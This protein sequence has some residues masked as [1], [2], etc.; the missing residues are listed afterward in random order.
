[1]AASRLIALCVIAAAV[2]THAGA[3]CDLPKLINQVQMHAVPY[4]AGS[5]VDLVPVTID[6]H[7][8]EFLLDTGGVYTQISPTLVAE[9]NLPVN[10][11]ADALVD[12]AGRQAAGLTMLRTFQLGSIT[13]QDVPLPLSPDAVIRTG[14]LSLNDLKPYDAEMDFG[15]NMLKLYSQ[16]HCSGVTAAAPSATVI[17]FSTVSG[18]I[19]LTVTLDGRA[20]PAIIDTGASYT[21][22]RADIAQLQFGAIPGGNDTPESGSINGMPNLTTYSHVF[23]SLALGG[24]TI[25]N[26]RVLILP[27][28]YQEGGK[29]VPLDAPE[30]ILGMNVLKDLDLYFAFDE[31][32]LYVKKAVAPP[33]S[34]P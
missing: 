23:T 26:P 15:S 17:P 24:I 29:T 20:I 12:V 32:K 8:S 14:L 21:D 11:T 6:G 10:R 5:Q 22:M 28:T 25:A 16:D 2:A 4:G 3:A 7:D 18:H 13:R 31:G 19:V 34:E 33:A 27:A 9:L 1:M 30:L